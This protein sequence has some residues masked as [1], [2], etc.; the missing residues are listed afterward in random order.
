M[1]TQGV[2]H[3]DGRRHSKTLDMSVADDAAK[4]RDRGRDECALEWNGIEFDCDMPLEA[5]VDL[6]E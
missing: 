1:V 4:G 5:R 3:G 2:R 6:F